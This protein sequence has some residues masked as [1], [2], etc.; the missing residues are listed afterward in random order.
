MGRYLLMISKVR[1]LQGMT[2]PRS[3]ASKWP[4]PLQLLFLVVLIL[5]FSSVF[6]LLAMALIKPIYGILGADTLLAEAAANPES[7]SGVDSKINALKFI[8]LCTTLGTFL[9]PAF[10]YSFVQDPMGDFIRLK[11]TGKPV[12]FGLAI[13]GMLCA[14]PMI[15]MLYDWNRNVQLPADIMQT[16]KRAEDQASALTHLFLEMPSYAALFFNLLVI[17]IMPA[18][19]EE[20]LFRGVLQRLFQDRIRNA[21]IAIWLTAAIFSLVHFQFLGFLPRM[22]LG[23]ILGYAFYYS[24]S[25]WVPVVAHAFNNSA[26]VIM[27]FLFQQ[28]IISYNVENTESTP[29]YLGILSLFI[30]ILIIALMYRRRFVFDVSKQVN[31]DENT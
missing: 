31:P 14:V 21:H 20:F 4:L 16:V 7:L 2:V 18:I 15:G 25:I 8:Q 29:I 13:L 11:Q 3:I 24:G 22:I 30:S 27:A 23:G 19:G 10:M 17:G 28:G 1:L 6:T 12:L 9:F 26:Q 5:S